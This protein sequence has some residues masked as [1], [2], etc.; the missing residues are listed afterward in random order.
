[1]GTK[2]PTTGHRPS[3]YK[4][5]IGQRYVARPCQ[6][7]QSADNGSLAVYNKSRVSDDGSRA[8]NDGSCTGDDWLQV[9]CI[10]LCP[11]APV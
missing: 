5:W 1:M 7:L 2:V 6:R 10:R 9:E 11:H 4:L 3:D 8:G